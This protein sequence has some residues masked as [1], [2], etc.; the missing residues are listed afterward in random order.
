MGSPGVVYAIVTRQAGSELMHG[1]S[2]AQGEN[3]KLKGISDQLARKSKEIPATRKG[4]R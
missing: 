3:D 4:D 2:K 1:D